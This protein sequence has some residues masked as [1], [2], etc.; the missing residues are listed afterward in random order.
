MKRLLGVCAVLSAMAGPA[1]AKDYD[2]G[3]ARIGM[4]MGQFR[5]AAWPAGLS[6]RCSDDVDRPKEVDRLLAMPRQM[7]DLG[8]VRCALL[9]VDEAG[10][11]SAATRRVGG[12]P[13]EVAATFA[14]D[15]GGT[16]RLVQ[17]FLQGPRDG[18]DGLVAH[19]TARLGPPAETD[20]R[21]VRWAEPGKEAIVL[22]E[23]GDTALAMMID[24]KMQ[25]AMNAKM[26]TRR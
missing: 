26:A 10:K 6:V 9:K 22:H 23:E 19:F 14:P 2:L 12:S 1:M 18:F 13:V 7:A 21:F 20:G 24:W 5:F 17:L 16:K 25:E 11:Y 8:A 3:Y 4:M 15:A